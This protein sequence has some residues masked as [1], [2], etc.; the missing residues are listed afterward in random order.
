MLNGELS[1]CLDVWEHSTPGFRGLC[2]IP[3]GHVTC[4]DITV[5]Q[6][7]GEA[8]EVTI[9]EAANLIRDLEESTPGMDDGAPTDTHAHYTLFRSKKPSFLETLKLNRL[10]GQSVSCD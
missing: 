10:T 8:R 9:E 4:P 6:A 7:G 2:E 3:R 5:A 1:V